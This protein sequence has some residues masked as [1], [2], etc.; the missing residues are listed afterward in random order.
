M[1]RSAQRRA[2]EKRSRASSRGE[3]GLFTEHIVRL[4]G[5]AMATCQ[6]NR[7]DHRLTMFDRSVNSLLTGMPYLGPKKRGMKMY[8]RILL[9]YD[10]S[11]ESRTALREGALMAKQILI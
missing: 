2:A 1:R 10:G 3:G 4:N 8:K 5:R 6:I 7:R 9:A 11:V